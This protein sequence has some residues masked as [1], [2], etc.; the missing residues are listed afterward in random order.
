MVH[1]LYIYIYVYIYNIYVCVYIFYLSIY[2]SIFLSNIH[3]YIY[4]NLSYFLFMNCNLKT[5]VQ[6]FNKEYRNAHITFSEG[7]KMLIY[8]LPQ[9]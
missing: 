1:Y 5:S 4:N 6:F 7:L 2:L 8:C 3:I 9:R